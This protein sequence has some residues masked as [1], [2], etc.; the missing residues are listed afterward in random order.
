MVVDSTSAPSR[1]ACDRSNANYFWD[2]RIHFIIE[3]CFL[4]QSHE[5]ENKFHLLKLCWVTF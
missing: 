1:K 5:L 2:Q 3:L 4:C